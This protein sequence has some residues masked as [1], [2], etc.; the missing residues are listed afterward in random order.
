MQFIRNPAFIFLYCRKIILEHRPPRRILPVIVI[1][2]F[3]CTS[4]WF[5]GN[6]VLPE[7]QLELDLKLY[8]VSLITSAIM[9]GFVTGTLLLALF[10]VT[11]RYS[12]VKLFFFHSLVG[13]ITN[14][15]IIWFARDAISLFALR[16]LTGICL[17]GI[18]PVGMKI[19]ADWFDKNLGKSLGFL[20]GALVLG[21]AFPHL[22]KSR[23]FEIPW[24]SVIYCTSLFTVAG[25]F[26]MLLM[27]GDG[28]YRKKFG[29]FQW[30]AIATVF[31]SVNWRRTAYGY[32]GHMFELYSFWGFIPLILSLYVSMK[33]VSLNVPLLSFLIIGA[34]A[35][36]CITG[37]YLSQRVGSARVA[38]YSLLISGSC[39]LL[40][41]LFFNLPV[42]F[43]I[44]VLFIWGISA[45]ADSPQF[46]ALAATYASPELRGS[47]LTFY[48][49][50]GFLITSFSL[51]ITDRLFY[52]KTFFGGSNTFM[53]LSLGAIMVLPAVKKLFSKP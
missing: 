18:Y 3:A 48:N 24:R 50:V 2:Q 32:F 6:A 14:A 1:S 26:L 36:G 41:P 42:Y 4:L 52:S 37:G 39:C 40:S 47:A 17:A 11:D 12:P 7:L 8:S 19:A 16:F 38:F 44:L 34:G 30:N 35:L 25:A 31:H 10:A 9:L 23:L 46:S 29:K 13:A 45:A 53:V 22:L 43:F 49:S 15:A 5:A 33:G 51:F 28:P 21:T 20:L 27:V